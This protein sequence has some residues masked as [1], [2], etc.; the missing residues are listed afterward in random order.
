MADK[1]AQRL[2]FFLALQLFPVCIILLLLHILACI[3]WGGGADNGPVGGPDPH[4]RSASSSKNNNNNLEAN[5]WQS[6]SDINRNSAKLALVLIKHHAMKAY[7][8]VK[9]KSHPFL[10]SED[11]LSTSRRVLITPGVKNSRYLLSSRL[12]G[13]QSRSGRCGQETNILPG[14]KPQF[15]SL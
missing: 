13:P 12:D 15:S 4:R 6:N 9:I 2:V 7:G 11:E 14:I 10:T 3:V 5:I 1:L 8:G